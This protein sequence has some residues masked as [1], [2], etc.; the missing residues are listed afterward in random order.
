MN[1]DPTCFQ[2]DEVYDEISHT[3][4]MQR[5]QEQNKVTEKKPKYI[6]GLLASAEQRKREN[7]RRTERQIQKEREQEG[8]QFEDKEQ[9]VTAAY[10]AKLK[11]MRED[12][13]RERLREAEEAKNDVT[14]QGDLSMF[15]RNILDQRT[16]G[17]KLAGE[18]GQKP[19]VVEEKTPSLQQAD[20]KKNESGARSRSKSSERRRSRS[21]SRSHETRRRR[22]RSR[23]MERARRR[24]RSKSSERRRS[25]RSRSRS[26]ERRR[27]RSGD[28]RRAR[29]PMELSKKKI[30]EPEQKE[31]KKDTKVDQKIFEKR[32]VD[33]SAVLSARERYLQRKKERS[34][35]APVDG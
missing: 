26:Y 17:P 3:S 32:N 13:E 29:S 2:Y 7:E 21:R 16:R 14:K 27:S 8:D 33:D 12:E 31:H 35:I 34:N 5:A 4:T 22:S 19:A 18:D 9:F 30:K 28:R 20:K 1:E 23:S 24:S 10:Q 25:R 6:A 15:Y 11:Q